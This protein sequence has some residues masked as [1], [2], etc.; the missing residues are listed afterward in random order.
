MKTKKITLLG[1]LL[2]LMLIL[3]LMEKQF[4]LVPGVPGI[5]PGLSNVVL[6]FALCLLSTKEAA[7]LL[8]LKVL[9]SGLLF[10]G[11]SGMAYA[12]CGGVLAFITMWLLLKTKAFGLPG[13]SVSGAVMHMLGQILCSRLLLGSWAAAAQIPVLLLSAVITGVLNGIIASHVIA[14]MK[15]TK[16]FSPAGRTDK[17]EKS[18]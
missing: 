6:M 12:F 5:K 11:V 18:K 4:V 10:A 8:L 1:V 2:S 7:A 15:K 16:L 17:E 14:A 13:V 3:G 9:L